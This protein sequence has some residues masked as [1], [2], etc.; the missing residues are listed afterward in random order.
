[1]KSVVNIADYMDSR[2][3]VPRVQLNGQRAIIYP[4]VDKAE[5]ATYIDNLTEQREILSF[6]LEGRSF[7]SAFLHP[8]KTVSTMFKLK[9]VDRIDNE[10][11]DIASTSVSDDDYMKRLKRFI[12][13]NPIR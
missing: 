7:I 6:F 1:M 3:D 9:R 11:S 2:K 8:F 10:L 12:K 4:F 5:I 13:Q